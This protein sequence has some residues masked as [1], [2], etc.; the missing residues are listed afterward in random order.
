MYHCNSI[1]AY[2]NNS[3]VNF[4][5]EIKLTI[6]QLDLYLEN[7]FIRARGRIVKADLPLDVTT[8]LF[9]PNRSHLVDLLI[10]HIHTSHN[11]IGLSQTLSLNRQRCWTPKIRSR[12]K[13]LL[14]RCV[15]CQKLKGG[16]IK[17]PLPPPLPAERV[18]WVPPFT[19]VG[20]DHTGHF[21]IRD[22]RGDRVKAYICIFVCTI[23]RAVHLKVVTSLSTSSFIMCLRRLAAAKGMPSL[24]LSDNHQTFSSGKAF[25]LEMQQDPEV[26]EY[27]SSKNIKWKHQTP[28][29]PRM[30][31]HFEI[32]VRTIK[33]SLASAI[34]KKLL[35]LEEFVTVVKEAENIVNSIPLTYQSDD[36]SDILLTPSQLAWGRDITLM[37]PLLQPGDPLDPD[38][39]AKKTRT[40]YIALSSAFERFRKWWLSEYL[41]SFREKHY[42]KCADNP[43]HH[44]RVGQLVIVKHKN[45]HRIEWPLGVITAVY[46]DEGGVIRTA[47]VEECGRR[48]IR[49]VTFL[50]PLELD[51]HREEDVIRQSLCDEEEGAQ[52]EHQDNEL[53]ADDI[54]DDA[55]ITH[56]VIDLST[57]A[58]GQGSPTLA[59][60]RDRVDP[61]DSSHR[62]PTQ[63]R[64]PGNSTES[65]SATST[66]E[67]CNAAAA[68]G[69]SITTSPN[70]SPLSQPTAIESQPASSRESETEVEETSSN[71]RQPRRTVI[72][73]RALMQE[74]LEDDLI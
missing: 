36:S 9:L 30:G 56:H 42:N 47:E 57:E 32:L 35:T 38:Y 46:P 23:T 31:G 3:R 24:I 5:L 66:T 37:P 19:H 15:V 26:Q 14:L 20:V 62:E 8:P 40:Q 33:A 12:T 58:R 43:Q 50:V 13:C 71:R 29:S 73:Q 1:H 16:T 52:E 51:C 49:S 72:R 65:C 18:K 17:R 6:K 68:E 25:L 39:D 7:D 34:S 48:S 4:N 55:D 69:D 64:T 74:L 53:Q 44:L 27:L 41:L 22:K 2:L 60:A 11:H 67:R 70:A 45:L 28:R 61:D 21:T 59:D 10:M 54:N 63:H